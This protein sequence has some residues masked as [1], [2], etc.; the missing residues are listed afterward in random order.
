LS[1]F[2]GLP[3]PTE[4]TPTERKTRAGALALSWIAYASYYLG[5]KNFSVVK[6]SVAR[7]FG[8][9]VTALA[10]VDTTYLVA[11]A[12]GQLPSG[13]AVDRFG[14]RRVVALGL[15]V[16]ACACA[17]F[18]SSS[19]AAAFACWFMLNGLAQAT[20]WSG[21]SQVVASWTSVRTRGRVMG[22]WS[23]CYQAGGI[24]A[25]A[26]ATWLLAHYGWRAAFRVPALWLFAVALLVL[27]LLRARSPTSVPR[28]GEPHLPAPW[29]AVLRMPALYSYGA[30]YF[31]IKLIRYSL[32][33]W[34]PYYLHT[35]AGF[36]EVA[37]GYLST[38]FE[39]GGVVGTVV[40]GYASDRFA[41]A[42]P[43]VAALSLVALACA[44]LVYA[45]VISHDAIW[46][47]ASLAL[48]GAL[49][50]GPDALLSGAAAQ[51][52]AGS[53]GAATAVGLVNGIGSVGALLQ[54]ALTVGV[55]RA[56]GWD[57]LFYVFV[58]LALA[59]AAC[60][61]PCLGWRARSA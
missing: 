8:L 27:T 58:G 10:L 22:L 5:R 16:S 19:S 29:R 25:T 53:A 14:A 42:R 61:L 45:R 30:C 38:A 39:I 28:V 44:L 24:A 15:T 56:A 46:H 13:V 40:I 3:L 51:D 49:L 50:F 48:I 4:H 26:L 59:A 17:L 41:Q 54:G 37:S 12:V 18:G 43:R 60:L 47:F 6:A 23:T 57:A 21:T 7:E 9:D 33:F 35:A 55:Q 31:C 20:G 32:L 34:L 2:G 36:D 11:Y 1:W 52:L